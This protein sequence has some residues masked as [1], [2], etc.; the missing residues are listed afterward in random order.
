MKQNHIHVHTHS[1]R[2]LNW[3]SAAKYF[4]PIYI[5]TKLIYLTISLQITNNYDYKFMNSNDIQFKP[6]LFTC[7]NSPNQTIITPLTHNRFQSKL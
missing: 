2:K 1:I 4:N 6:R 7:N 5:S 3:K